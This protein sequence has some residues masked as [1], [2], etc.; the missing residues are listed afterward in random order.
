M[1]DSSEKFNEP[2][3]WETDFRQWGRRSQPELR[4]FFYARLEAR[5]RSGLD[6]SVEPAMWL[7][8]W[9]RRPAY[10]YAALSLLVLLNVGAVIGL[11]VSYTANDDQNTVSTVF[12]DEY[13]IEPY[14]TA[15]E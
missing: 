4:P 6:Q 8:F 7:P 15:Y 1:K 14:I 11:S 3:R 10:A 13:S 9:L 12:Q 2:D 5:L